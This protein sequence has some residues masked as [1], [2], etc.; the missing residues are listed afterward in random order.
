MYLLLCLSFV[1]VA[2]RREEWKA[3][4][5]IPLLDQGYI[6]VPRISSI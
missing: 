1:R 3:L 6:D 4:N 2:V 5:A